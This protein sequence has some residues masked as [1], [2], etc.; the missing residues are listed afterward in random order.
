M[1]SAKSGS[2]S[3]N[4]SY[5]F[6]WWGEGVFGILKTLQPE[7]GSLGVIMI[8]LHYMFIFY[9]Y[10]YIF[11]PITEIF[12]KKAKFHHPMKREGRGETIADG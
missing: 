3:R 9:T 2:K 7:V 12:I 6:H 5:R 1:L 10:L 11:I 4:L 8:T